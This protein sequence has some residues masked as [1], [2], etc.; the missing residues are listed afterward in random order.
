MKEEPDNSPPEESPGL[1]LVTVSSFPGMAAAHTTL[2]L[3]E[4]ETGVAL[5]EEEEC[6]LECPLEEEEECPPLQDQELPGGGDEE[7]WAPPHTEEAFEEPD[8]REAHQAS[9]ILHLNL[10]DLTSHPA[11]KWSDVLSDFYKKRVKIVH[12]DKGGDEAGFRQVKNAYKCLKVWLTWYTSVVD[13]LEGAFG[14]FLCHCIRCSRQWKL[15]SRCP[16]CAGLSNRQGHIGC[17]LQPGIGH[18]RRAYPK[19]YPKFI[20]LLAHGDPLEKAKE[21]IQKEGLLAAAAKRKKEQLE[22]DLEKK[23]R[24]D[25]ER[26]VT[27]DWTRLLRDQDRALEDEFLQ[28]HSIGDDADLDFHLVTASP[29]QGLPSNAPPAVVAA[30]LSQPLCA[31]SA[32]PGPAHAPP[33]PPQP[34]TVS[35]PPVPPPPPVSATATPMA[36][37]PPEYT[38]NIMGRPVHIPLE[39]EQFPGPYHTCPGCGHHSCRWERYNRINGR[40]WFRC[41]RF[42]SG[43]CKYFFYS[44][45]NLD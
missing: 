32:P 5:E 15:L 9:L 30:H 11:E 45:H 2:E 38:T 26:K 12:P 29:A 10:A 13:K 20:A 18:L 21:V 16:A 6:P 33:A 44:P 22:R 36:S 31:A 25:R 34:V 8:Q 37:H 41:T 1:G 39:P 4:E 7:A 27:E 35:E 42:R 14:P 3:E 24:R 43:G 23:Q 19:L 40:R 28:H 17:G